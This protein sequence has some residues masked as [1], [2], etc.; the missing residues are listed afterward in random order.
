[1]REE[2]GS[3]MGRGVPPDDGASVGRAGAPDDWPGRALL[4]GASPR[5]ILAKLCDGDPLELGPRVFEHLQ[6]SAVL[7]DPNRAC[8]RAAA[9]VAYAAMRYRGAPE[10]GVFLRRCI[11]QS[12]AE[13]V[14]E[15]AED[16]VASLLNDDAP[17]AHLLFLWKLLGIEPG[18]ARR[19]SIVFNQQPIEVRR[20]FLA[21]AGG[22]MAIREYSRQDGRPEE[23]VREL[24]SQA[25]R[26]MEAAIGKRGLSVEGW[27]DHG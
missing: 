18:L 22:R 16:E 8:S 5:A 12:V 14:E 13:L 7:V 17:G 4:Q 6:A 25:L 10:L 3:R 1:M 20:A 23:G 24:L 11:E 26:A 27:D 9:R 21:V 19:A 15:E 2:R